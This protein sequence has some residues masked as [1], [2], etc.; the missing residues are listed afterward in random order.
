MNKYSSPNNN[1]VGGCGGVVVWV[2]GCEFVM[3]I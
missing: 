1:E 3:M 2:V